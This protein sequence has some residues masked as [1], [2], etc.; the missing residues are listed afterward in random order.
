MR[1]E[2]KREMRRTSKRELQDSGRGGAV[3]KFCRI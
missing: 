1:R 3:A 2:R